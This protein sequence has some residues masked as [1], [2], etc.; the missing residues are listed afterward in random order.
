LNWYGLFVSLD[1]DIRWNFVFDPIIG[2]PLHS[3]KRQ[4]KFARWQMSGVS[5]LDMANDITRN[6][7]LG[8]T[9][10]MNPKR[11]NADVSPLK[12]SGV[13]LLHFDLLLQGCDLFFQA[14]KCEPRTEKSCGCGYQTSSQCFMSCYDAAERHRKFCMEEIAVATG[15]LSLVCWWRRPPMR[16]GKEK[17]HCHNKEAKQ[18]SAGN[19][20]TS[21]HHFCEHLPPRLRFTSTQRQIV[22][23]QLGNCR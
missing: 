7:S 9:P 5:T 8:G 23:D 17:D 1:L 2:H 20:T 12:Y 4:L 3:N 16:E 18:G 14:A 19:A 6:T 21:V 22:S 15:C 10:R 11:L 13:F